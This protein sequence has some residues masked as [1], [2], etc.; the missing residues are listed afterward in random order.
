MVIN[1]VI[2]RETSSK[3]EWGLQHGSE[4]TLY[5][6]DSMEHVR[7][8]QLKDKVADLVDL[9]PTQASMV[10]PPRKEMLKKLR[11]ELVASL[12]D[13]EKKLEEMGGSAS[14]VTGSVASMATAKSNGTK[15]SFKAPSTVAE[16]D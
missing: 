11:G 6:L 5:P 10:R 7:L 12:E 15:K 8:E 16:E 9:Q 3:V 14:T 13:V 1:E 2:K 4:S